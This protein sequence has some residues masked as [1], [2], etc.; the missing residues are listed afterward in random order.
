MTATELIIALFLSMSCT[1]TAIDE[2]VLSKETYQITS[3]RCTTQTFKVWQ[4]FCHEGRGYYSRP[5]LITE[6]HTGESFY[7]N[8]FGEIM[9][10][11][12]IE[13]GEVYIPTC[14]V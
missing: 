3:Y 11:I 10:G 12:R 14:G 1:I 2:T 13:I 4:R 9:A 6:T 8:R 5:F 7:L